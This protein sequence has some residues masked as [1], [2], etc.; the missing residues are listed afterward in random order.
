M[1]TTVRTPY[2]IMKNIS[3]DNKYSPEDGSRASSQ[4]NIS[5]IMNNISSH[6]VY[7]ATFGEDLSMC[8][9]VVAPE[10]CMHV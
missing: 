7:P 10:L 4:N 5:L 8:L 6:A 9:A 1:V 2:V 3:K